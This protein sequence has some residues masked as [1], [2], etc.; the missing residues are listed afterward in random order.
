MKIQALTITSA[1]FLSLFMVPVTCAADDSSLSGNAPL[2]VED[3]DP[4]KYGSS[5]LEISSSYERTGEG[6]SLGQFQ[7]EFK[8]GFAKNTHVAISLPTLFGSDPDRG[9]G[10]VGVS[11]LSRSAARS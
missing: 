11:L 1:L 5:Q 9:F 4:T 7:P 8:Y 2:R 10:D 6:H 3:A